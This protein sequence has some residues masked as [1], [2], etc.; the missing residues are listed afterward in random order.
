MEKRRWRRLVREMEMAVLSDRRGA[1][2]G[3]KRRYVVM[4]SE[5]SRMR[6][7]MRDGF[8][9]RVLFIFFGGERR[10]TF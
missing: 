7:L 3:W 9:A 4:K 5:R 2:G 1:W 10:V 6:S 8:R